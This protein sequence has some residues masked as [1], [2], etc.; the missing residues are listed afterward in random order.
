MY[1]NLEL[2]IHRLRQ[3]GELQ[4]IDVPVDPVLEIAEIT[5][6]MSKS[7]G[8][9]KAL[10]FND[11]GTAYPV[12]T[13]MYGSDKRICLAL[14]VDSLDELSG[15]IYEMFEAV[16]SPKNT[17]GDKVK[18]LP[19][20]GRV[21]RWMP[22]KKKGRGPCQEVIHDGDLSSFPVLKCWKF[23]GG[24]F[25]T[26][27]MV[28]TRDPAT[29]IRNVGMYRM[30]VFSGNTT[31]M[32]WHMHKTGARHYEEY[33]RLGKRMPVT[34]CLGGDPAYTYSAT[35]PLPDNIDEFLLAGFIR[36]KPVELVKCLTND[37][38]IPAD[39]DFVIEGYVDPQE[40]K[41]IEGAFGDHTG[42]Y[43][44][45]D[46]YPLFH[47]TCTTHRKN[48]VYPATIV[49][50]P[51]QEDMYIAKATEKIFL[52]PI[53]LAIQPEINDLYMPSEGV[54]HNIAVVDID[55]KYPGQ[56]FKVAA[57]MWGA[58]QMMFNKF[59]LITSGCR[60]IRNPEE[61]KKN[62]EKVSIPRDVMFSKGPLDVLDHTSDI[63]G[64][65]GKVC[66]DATD[67]S[68]EGYAEHQLADI[69]IPKE[70]CADADII[71]V[72]DSLA[73]EWRALFISV[74]N[75]GKNITGTVELIEKYLQI[76]SVEGL[77][78]IFVYDANVPLQD[79][80]MLIW[81]AGGNCDAVRDI[82][83]RA[84]K[85]YFDA[86]IK[87]G[88]I[89]GFRRRFPNVV[90]SDM[91]TIRKVDERWAEYGIGEFIPSPSREYSVLI[92]DGSSGAS[93]DK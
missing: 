29:G 87:A 53:R 55:K 32:H 3:E 52:A 57:S 5:D 11:T 6:R 71:S 69:K 35:A 45:E 26:L 2:Y 7:P 33:K 60:D 17:F 63:L 21:S 88:G 66:I 89:N 30:Q 12:L 91:D 14:G 74:Q 47:V 20:L 80:R 34:V 39:C 68:K 23:D 92:P 22:K 13:N 15:R 90:T 42:F 44:L 67:K 83:I 62:L 64:F 61:L 38:E 54:A 49:G 50:I 85:I 76:N 10:L 51:P 36:R 9:G 78:Y 56:G 59:L 70:W 41:V 27:P 84:D 16:T 46:D 73:E 4:E 65:G 81:L 43:S 24:R 48:A 77:N 1:A 8:G 40:D 37:L 19:V 31:G 79:V 82:A 93:I 58:G 72:N 75:N 86:R 25:V 18:M 28:I